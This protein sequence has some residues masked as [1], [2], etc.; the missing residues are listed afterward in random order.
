[1]CKLQCCKVIATTFLFLS[2]LPNYSLARHI[3]GGEM[4]Y[5]CLGNGDYEIQLLIYR[6]CLSGGGDF[7]EEANIAIYQCGNTIDC[8]LLQ[9]GSQSLNFTVPLKGVTL[10]NHPDVTCLLPQI[11]IEQGVYKFRTSEF[12]FFLPQVNNSYHIVYQRCCRNE[13]ITNIN[14]PEETGSTYTVEITPEAQLACNTS[15][16]FNTF[17]PAVICTNK[18]FQFE[19][20][21]VDAEGDSLVYAFTAPLLGGGLDLSIEGRATCLGVTPNPS[22]PPP[23]NQVSFIGGAFNNL[24][25]FGDDL[26]INPANGI[27]SGTPTLQG[28]YVASISV[29][30][31]RNG[32]LLSTIQREFQITITDC[33]QTNERTG[34][35][36]DDGNSNTENDRIQFDCTCKGTVK[37]SIVNTPDLFFSEYI[38]GDGNNK[39]LEIYNPLDIAVDL[40]EYE[41]KVFKDGSQ[42]GQILKK[43]VG[44]L[45]PKSIYTICNSSADQLL[46]D[47][48]DATFEND[49]DGNDALSLEKNNVFIDLFGNIGCD[50]GAAW[51]NIN[52]GTQNQTLLRCP[53]VQTGVKVDPNNCDFPTLSTEWIGLPNGNYTNLGQSTAAQ[54]D[55]PIIQFLSN[56]SCNCQPI[57]KT[58]DSLALVDLYLSLIHI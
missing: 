41:V 11:C 6:D 50:P 9:Q 56:F 39:C 37:E 2:L 26:Q 48:A 34:S 30:E 35:A 28:H 16:Q 46:L 23:Y 45:G 49:Y 14:S 43:L 24:H 42:N 21:A 27:I 47:I 10:A 12:Q 15:P 4:S 17:P 52:T 38:E 31:Y 8:S 54:I 1:M 53:C 3:V 25:P 22:C 19:H 58:V 18:P 33:E 51:S 40:S 7:D 20:K 36:C 57:C 55:D 44:N 13:T 29:A 32:Q 5:T